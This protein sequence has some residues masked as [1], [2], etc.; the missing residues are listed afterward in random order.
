MRKEGKD[1]RSTED[2]RE[3]GREGKGGVLGH[4]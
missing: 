3:G 4:R 1:L 2:I